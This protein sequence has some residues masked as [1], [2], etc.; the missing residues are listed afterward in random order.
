MFALIWHTGA[1]HHFAGPGRMYVLI[2]K[3]DVCPKLFQYVFFWD[4]AQ[5]ERFIDPNVP[6]AQR[7]DDTFL[8][9]CI[10]RGHQRGADRHLI[11]REALL[12]TGKGL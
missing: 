11:G 10:A 2:V 6:C 9:R 7:P 5:K 3:K 8:R 4:A 1:G 12:Q